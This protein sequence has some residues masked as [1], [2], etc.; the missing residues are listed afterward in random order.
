MA[1]SKGFATRTILDIE[2]GFGMEPSVKAGKSVPFNSNGVVGTRELQDPG[3]IT[4][5]RNAPDPF[6]GN[7][8]ANGDLVVPADLKAFGWY[9]RAMF[10][11]P[12]TTGSGTYTH[13]FKISGNT[14]P[15]LVLERQFLSLASRAAMRVSGCRINRW[16]FNPTGGGDELVHTFGIIGANETKILPPSTLPYG[17][18]V[19]AKTFTGAGTVGA[20][21]F[22]GS[23]LNDATSGGTFT[24]SPSGSY[25]VQIDS[26]GATDTFK[27]SKDGGATWVAETVAITGAAQTL[28][29][30][31]T[32]TFAATTGHTSA[33]RWDIAVTASLED[34]TLGTANWGLGTTNYKV[35][36]DAAAATDTFKWSNDGGSTWKAT[37]VAMTGA[38]Q[39]LENG[40]TVLFAATTGHALNTY[41]TFTTTGPTDLAATMSRIVNAQCSAM[42]EG[43]SGFTQ[44]RDLSLEV[45]FGLDTEDYRLAGAGIRSDLPEGMVAVTGTLKAIFAD[46]ALLDKAIA[47]TESSLQLTWTKSTHSLVILLPEVKYSRKGPAVDGPKGIMQELAFKAY[48]GN[49]TDASAIKVTLVNDVASYA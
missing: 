16:A 34:L 2:N 9:L 4:G 8:D 29:K 6:M 37:G 41:W 39:E 23:G 38:A 28:E 7:M 47:E 22:T 25:R 40:V 36:V 45:A 49:G 26:T 13:V 33:D 1:Q 20:A 43:G 5:T 27:W 44:A 15:S 46:F 32:V 3:T 42:A 35:Q 21:S 19:G 48:Y 14:M 24:G 31:V 12:V 17:A 11:A 18:A 30:G 10:G